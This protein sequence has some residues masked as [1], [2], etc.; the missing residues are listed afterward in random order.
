MNRLS[1]AHDILPRERFDWGEV[2]GMAVPLKAPQRPATWVADLSPL[3]RVL[4]KG[5]DAAG[6]LAARGLPVPEDWFVCRDL[7]EL[8]DDVFMA[9]TGS[10]EFLLHDGPGGALAE[11]LGPLPE[12]LENGTRVLARDDQE[13]A[14]GGE[15]AAM[16]M[17]EFCALDLSTTGDALLYTRVAGVGVWLRVEAGPVYRMGCEPSYGEFLFETLMHGV[18]EMQGEVIGFSDFYTIREDPK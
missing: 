15:H 14:L 3:T 7:A 8:G 10:G 17:A 4:V 2:R 9:R 16:L 5:G 12:G 18:R 6:W 11:R 13:V 1:P